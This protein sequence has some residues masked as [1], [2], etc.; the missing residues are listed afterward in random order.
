M[1]SFELG[2]ELRKMRLRHERGTKK[3]LSSL[4]FTSQIIVLNMFNGVIA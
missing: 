4:R 2:E 1:V 3:Q